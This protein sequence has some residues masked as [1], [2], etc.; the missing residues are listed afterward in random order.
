[1][2]PQ[3]ILINKNV[4]GTLLKNWRELASNFVI[5]FIS[6]HDKFSDIGAL[7]ILVA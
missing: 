1:M 2:P 3:M 7:P 4:I 5:P 6:I